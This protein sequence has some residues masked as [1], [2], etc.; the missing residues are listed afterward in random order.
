MFLQLLHI[1]MA[2][3]RGWPDMSEVDVMATA[4]VLERM[5]CADERTRRA[6]LS[7]V[8]EP[9]DLRIAQ[10]VADH[11]VLG[12]IE[13]IALPD[14][15][16][17]LHARLGARLT[18]SDPDSDLEKVRRLGGR[19]VIP[20]DLEWPTQ[21]DDLGIAM[22]WALWVRGSQDLR[23]TMLRSVALVGARACTP[24]G[25]RIA[26]DMASDLASAGWTVVSGGAFGI[27]AAAHRGALAV[28][29]I[30][31]AVLACGVDVSYPPRNESMF[32]LIGRDGFLISE[33]APGA[34]PHR[35]RFLVRNRVIAALTRGTVVIE[36]AVRSGS[37]ATARAALDLDRPVLGTPGPI[38]SPL[39][40][41]VHQILRN[42]AHLVTC[43]AEVIEAVGELGQDL[44]PI[45]EGTRAHLDL[46]DSVARAVLD[47]LPSRGVTSASD[48]AREAGVTANEVL[49][50]LTR[51]EL[52]GLVQR[53]AGGWSIVR[54]A[55]M[56]GAPR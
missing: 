44:A 20:G 34:V 22:P 55:V 7:S 54:R 6:L 26:S 47:A 46:I 25:A 56:G 27:D 52:E 43:A 36:A 14:V 42:G 21:L 50:A 40:S 15:M 53:R 23:M 45:P 1:A 31:A 8:A 29:G 41:G 37:L 12:T 11:G 3:H 39:S 17:E 30:T 38:T 49:V 28:N 2:T 5:R 19:L 16:P 13:R 48:V 9:G 51:L 18:R 35:A 32:E 33:V 10:F 24:Y 4:V